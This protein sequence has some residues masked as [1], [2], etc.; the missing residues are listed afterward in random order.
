MRSEEVRAH[1]LQWPEGWERTTYECRRRS[2]FQVS[3]GRAIHDLLDELGRLGARYVTISSN[4]RVRM[5]GI[6]YATEMGKLYDDPGVAIYFELKGKSQVIACDSYD[7]VHNN[8]RAVGKTIEAMR[9]IERHGSTSILNRAFQGFVALPAKKKWWQVLGFDS[10]PGPHSPPNGQTWAVI[11]HNY[12][13]LSH[14]HHPDKG[15]SLQEMQELNEAYNE[16]KQIW[17]PRL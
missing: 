11:T 14:Q 2:A 16:T 4:V 3:E 5:D 9:A 13:E 15:G 10:E 12:R 17:G 1:P 6:P 7:R 8:I